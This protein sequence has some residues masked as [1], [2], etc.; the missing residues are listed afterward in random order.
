L[1]GVGANDELQ[2]EAQHHPDGAYQEAI[3]EQGGQ[4]PQ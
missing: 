3:V 4:A 1:I 2:G